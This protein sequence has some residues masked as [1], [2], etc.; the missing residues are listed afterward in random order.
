M[1]SS[2]NGLT[3]RGQLAIGALVIVLT[4]GGAFW[5]LAN[6]SSKFDEQRKR[7]DE[8]EKASLSLREHEEYREQTRR[9][10]ERN[11]ADVKWLRDQVFELRHQI[12]RSTCVR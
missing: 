2:S 10:I 11:E 7:I 3:A 12:D 4:I 1:A 5:S 8:V 9:A 6:P